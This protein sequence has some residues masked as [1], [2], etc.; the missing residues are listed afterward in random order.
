[1]NEAVDVQLLSE[2]F[3]ANPYPT[4]ERLRTQAPVY[5]FE[6]FQC[7][8]LTRAADIEALVKD[9]RFTARRATELFGGLGLIGEDV[10]SKKMLEGWSRMVLFQDAPRQTLLR[11]LIMKALKPAHIEA[12]RPRLAATAQQ[13]LTRARSQGELDIVADF[14]EPLAITAIAELFALPSAD[15]HQFLKWSRDILKPAGGGALPEEAKRAFKQSASELLQ[16]LEH[17]VEERRKHPGDDTVSRLIA[18]EGESP[19]LVGEAVLQSFQLIGA[20][21]VTSQN[22]IANSVLVLLKHPKELRKLREAPGL[23]QSALEE[24]LRHEPSGL[25]IHRLSMEDTELHGTRIPKGR[26]V[27]G[28]FA[29]A[30]RDPEVFPDPARFDI[31]RARNRHMTFGVGSHYCLGA[32]IIRLELEEAIRAL[33]SL[34]RWE[35]VDKPLDYAGSNFQDR[36]PRS[37]HVRFPGA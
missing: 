8:V 37:L 36:G 20:G 25:A 21:F 10:A 19:E 24:C 28:M 18:A 3:F 26:F 11:Q 1:M 34:P 15:R 6:P 35:L 7:F 12:L 32:S 27:Y 17:L 14:A 23:L 22:Q 5:F 33:L 2:S 30:N 16:Y 31:T 4:F 29:A 9:P 13:A